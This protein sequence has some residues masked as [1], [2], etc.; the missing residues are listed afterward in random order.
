M[1]QYRINQIAAQ[2]QTFL[3]VIPQP[4][5]EKALQLAGGLVLNRNPL[6]F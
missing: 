2:F 5:S 1:G 3:T 4:L 6:L